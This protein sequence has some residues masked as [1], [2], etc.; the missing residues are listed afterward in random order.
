MCNL[1]D[2]LPDLL[3]FDAFSGDWQ[4][5]EDAVFA[6]FYSDF[7]ESRPT[8]LNEP[9]YITKNPLKKGKERGFWHCIQQGPI[10]EERTADLRRCE[11]IGW[12][13]SVIEHAADPIIKKWPKQKGS[14][15]R[16]LLWVEEADYLVVIEKRPRCWL[17]C[18]AYCTNYVHTRRKLRAEYAAYTKSQRRPV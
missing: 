4:R 12:I 2:W 9:V 15:H 6:Q 11:R 10:E 13:K 17:L 18:T 7:I 3:L 16:Y 1:P 14:K 5:Y 8:F